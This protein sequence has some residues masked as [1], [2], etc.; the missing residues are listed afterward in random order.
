MQ[1]HLLG[2][3]KESRRGCWWTLHSRCL[4]RAEPQP[5]TMVVHTMLLH[6]KA[7][8]YLIKLHRITPASRGHGAH[9]GG[10]VSTVPGQQANHLA[11][12]NVACSHINNCVHPLHQ[13][14][15]PCGSSTQP[16]S[17]SGQSAQDEQW[18]HQVGSPTAS[19]TG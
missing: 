2:L 13:R 11:Y 4:H 6:T 10:S 5:I 7:R 8:N 16:E 12:L 1:Q 18:W 14:N 17:R 9:D 19:N 3:D 15:R